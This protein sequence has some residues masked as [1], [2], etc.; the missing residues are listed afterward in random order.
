HNYSKQYLKAQL[1]YAYGGR[2]A[3]ELVFGTEMITTGAG[4][5]IERATALARRMITEWGM[6]DKVGPMNVG[7]RGDEIFLGREIVERRDVSEQM[8]Q[9]V[10]TEVRVLL[11]EAY[12]LARG[13]IKENIDKLHVLAKALLERETLDSDEIQS[14]FD[15]K[16]LPPLPDD[17]ANDERSEAGLAGS[18]APAANRPAAAGGVGD[19]LEPARAAERSKGETRK[20]ET[21]R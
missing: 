19:R 2:V 5:D 16:E 21:S 4:N 10:D 6:S 7:D 3:E 20:R 12:K 8:S 9:M 11:D 14:V 18:G 1:V 13:V 15:G 17:K